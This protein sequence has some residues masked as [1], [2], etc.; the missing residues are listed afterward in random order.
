MRLEYMINLM[1]PSLTILLSQ[2]KLN[3]MKKAQVAQESLP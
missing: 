3:L 2:K 1:K